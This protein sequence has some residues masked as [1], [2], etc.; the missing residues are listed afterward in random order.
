M[1]SVADFYR[2]LDA[3]A[4]FSTAEKWDNVG[5]IVGSMHVPASRV[6]L[7]L[8]VTDFVLEE[9]KNLG[10]GLII[11]H[12]PPIFKPISSLSA[13]SMAYKLAAA[14]IA[15]ISAHTNLDVANGGVNDALVKKLGF[16]NSRGLQPYSE[17]LWLG[18][19]CELEAPLSSKELVELV[20]RQL[21]VGTVRL[22]DCGKPI[23]TVAVCGGSGFVVLQ[24][25][26]N[27]GAQAIITGE[28]R[29]DELLLASELGITL[30]DA[31]HHNTEAVV[32]EPLM[33]AL[34]E[35]LSG[36]EIFISR[37]TEPAL[38]I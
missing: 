8:D 34:S 14:G 29:H 20:K 3:L 26:V 17:D 19:I 15:L 35:R 18:R 32:L 27:A 16:A 5:L 28:G 33:N 38:Y 23:R 2:E 24:D 1:L 36:C 13:E 22:V 30:I 10:C 11:T 9:A 25:A 7:A 6:L 4:P 31:G 21:G 37:E 12:H